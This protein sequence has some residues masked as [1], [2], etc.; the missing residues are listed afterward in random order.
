MKR[1]CIGWLVVLLAAFAPAADPPARRSPRE[2]LQ[3][4]HDLIGSWR[5]TGTPDGTRE[6]QQRG[7]WKE[8][9]YWQWQF[10]GPDAW[11]KVS[12]EK[13]KHFTEGELRYLPD[14]DGFQLTLF[15]PA[16]KALTFAGRLSDRRLTLERQDD[17][18]KE[19]QRL[20]FTLLHEN[21]FLYRYEVKAH[22]R[23]LFT[24]L[25]QV[26]ATKEG[27]PFAGPAD[28]RP[29]CVVSGGLG[30]IKVSY[31]GQTYFVCC[32]GCRDAFKDEPEKFLKEYQE[33]K[34]KEK[35]GQ[36]GGGDR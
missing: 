9:I 13:G 31:K 3:A 27:V 30:T 6:E 19:T 29:E 2:A 14:T 16:D 33:R 7:F 35:A 22:H 20:V 8:S 28:S 23:P 25:Y 4:F 26:G 12:F 10:K 32:T 1:V 11:L 34:A 15:T 21:R 18:K 24:R 36:K 17:A 5:A